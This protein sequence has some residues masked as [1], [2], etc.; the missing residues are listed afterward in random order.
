MYVYII[1]QLEDLGTHL[2]VCFVLMGIM[3]MTGEEEEEKKKTKKRR[4]L[5]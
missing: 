3:I 2:I 5:N 4:N 1:K